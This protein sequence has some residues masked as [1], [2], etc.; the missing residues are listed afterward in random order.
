MSA[1]VNVT[2]S[3][4]ITTLLGAVAG[5]IVSYF[6]SGKVARDQIETQYS[7]QNKRERRDWYKRTNELAGL[8]S[9]DWYDVMNSGKVDYEVNPTEKFQSN[10]EELRKHAAV[11]Q[12]LDVDY[13]VVSKLEQSA[14]NFKLSLSHLDS[15]TNLADIEQELIPMLSE[16]Q[17][18]SHEKVSELS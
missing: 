15:G 17:E 9:S 14:A 6:V 11:G 8:A 3:S 2:D 4:I 13:E 1:S 7:L 12:S 10:R 18:E 16:V 5:G